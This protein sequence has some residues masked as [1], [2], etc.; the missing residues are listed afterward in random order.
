MEIGKITIAN[1]IYLRY[2]FLTLFLNNSVI[3]WQLK[4]KINYEL[5][6]CRQKMLKQQDSNLI[7][8]FRR[9]LFEIPSC[10]D[11][12]DDVHWITGQLLLDDGH[13]VARGHALEHVAALENQKLYL[14]IFASV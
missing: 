2:F 10:R 8:G 13:R 1:H 12:H 5:T 14:L 3:L 7:C 9:L 4:T 11:E 6:N